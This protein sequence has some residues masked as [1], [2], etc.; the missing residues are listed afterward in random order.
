[1]CAKSFQAKSNYSFTIIINLYTS[2]L[3]EIHGKIKVKMYI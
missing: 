3:K 2:G 1:M